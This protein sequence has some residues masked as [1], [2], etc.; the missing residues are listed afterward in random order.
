MTGAMVRAGATAPLNPLKLTEGNE[1]GHFE[2]KV[3]MELNDSFL[4]QIGSRWNDWRK[5]DLHEDLSEPAGRLRD[6]TAAVLAQ[7]YGDSAFFVL[8]DPRICRFA[9]LWLSAFEQA[10]ISVRIVIPI[11]S[12]FEVAASLSKRSGFSLEEGVLIWLRHVLDAERDTRGRPRCFVSMDDLLDDWRATLRRIATELNI[13]WP[14]LNAAAE[15]QIDAYLSREL[16]HENVAEAGAGPSA[17]AWASSAFDALLALAANPHATSPLSSLDAVSREFERACALFGPLVS[18]Q[19][20]FL[21]R[22]AADRENFVAAHKA[23]L[24]E[25]ISLAQQLEAR[26]L[27]GERKDAP[28][29]DKT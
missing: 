11:R 8:K 7:E 29:E 28:A 24:L 4:E 12:P 9:P 26:Q 22:L 5:I 13:S 2:S 19:E 25:N 18:R 21:S 14:G 6:R 15:A 1:R 27:E 16:K 20:L 3:V 10:R 17:A 23:L